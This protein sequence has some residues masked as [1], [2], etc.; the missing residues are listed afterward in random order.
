MMEGAALYVF[1]HYSFY[2][3]V[4]FAPLDYPCSVEKNFT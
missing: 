3:I 2:G 4:R 1:V